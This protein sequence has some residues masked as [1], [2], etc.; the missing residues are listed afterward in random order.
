MHRRAPLLRLPPLGAF[1]ICIQWNQMEPQ[2]VETTGSQMGCNIS[3]VGHRSLFVSQMTKC[4]ERTERRIKL[5]LKFHAGHIF[6]PEFGIQ[7]PSS[8][9]FGPVVDDWVC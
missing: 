1:G 4:V 2:N 5:P 9:T 7:P 3:E 8:Q 6:A